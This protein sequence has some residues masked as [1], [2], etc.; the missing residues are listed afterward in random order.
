MNKKNNPETDPDDTPAIAL[1]V[2]VSGGP[3]GLKYSNSEQN[4]H[5]HTHAHTDTHTLDQSA[6]TAGAESQYGTLA[7]TQHGMTWRSQEKLCASS[8]GSTETLDL[9]L[10]QN[11]RSRQ[12]PL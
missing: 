4:I 5:A 8:A 1:S 6:E 2:S 3:V 12:P 7:H 10:T 9:S 11:H